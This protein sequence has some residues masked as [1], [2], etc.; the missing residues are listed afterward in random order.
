AFPRHTWGTAFH[1]NFDDVRNFIKHD[2]V[3]LKADVLSALKLTQVIEVNDKFTAWIRS[4]HFITDQTLRRACSQE[5][6][7]ILKN[8]VNRIPPWETR[9]RNTLREHKA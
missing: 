4:V 7:C 8:S 9:I 1:I 3:S 2:L 5:R 6:V